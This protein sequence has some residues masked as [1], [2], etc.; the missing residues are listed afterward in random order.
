MGSVFTVKTMVLLFHPNMDRSLVNK[1]LI[2]AAKQ[3][4]GVMIRDM[5]DLYRNNKIS[6]NNERKL[7]LGA[8]RIV[9]QFPLRW[10]SAPSLLYKWESQVFDDYWLNSG[11][12]GE[13]VLTGKE[14][15]LTVAHSEPSYDFTPEGK[16]HY[17]LCQ[18]LHPF[19]VVSMHIGTTYCQPVSIYELD[20]LDKTAKIYADILTK[21]KLTV[22]KPTR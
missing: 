11:P 14:L 1:K 4:R 21:E 9:F 20:D 15:M 7:L 2:A 6:I 8:D 16:Y 19:E 10:Y 22:Q 12:D 18:L 13:K 5:Y 3:K 17:S